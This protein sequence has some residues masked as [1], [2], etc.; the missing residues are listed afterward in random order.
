[1]HGSE[2]I[3]AEPTI[4]NVQVGGKTINVMRGMPQ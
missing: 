2:N 4:E 3:P 1:L